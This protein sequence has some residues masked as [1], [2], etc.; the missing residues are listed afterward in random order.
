MAGPFKT[1]FGNR[2][3]FVLPTG[4]TEEENAWAAAKAR[5]DLET[6]WIRGNGSFDAIDDTRARPEALKGRNVVLYGNAETNR[7]WDWFI[8][9]RRLRVDR[10]RVALGGN[11]QTG[12]LAVLAVLPRLDGGLVGVVGGTDLRGCRTTDRLPYF[13]AGVHYPDVTVLR[14]QA[15]RVGPPGVAAVA[16]FGWDWAVES[17]TVHFRKQEEST[18]EPASLQVKDL[19]GADR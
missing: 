1:V 19:A 2:A 15:L 4:G 18:A 11:E 7:A 16:M 9:A 8:G 5:Y 13:L 3:V 6:W 12:S 17:G 14:P 10:S